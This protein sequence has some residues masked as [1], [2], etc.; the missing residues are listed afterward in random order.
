MTNRG[1]LLCDFV[2]LNNNCIAVTADIQ[3][4]IY[5]KLLMHPEVNAETC[6]PVS[7]TGDFA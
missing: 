2:K 6:L 7:M 5:P 4:T 3:L 1:S